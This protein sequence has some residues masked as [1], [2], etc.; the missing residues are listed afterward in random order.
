MVQVIL[1]RL[2]W[3]STKSKIFLTQKIK[4]TKWNIC[5]LPTYIPQEVPASRIQV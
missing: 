3:G 4:G 2:I 1:E 5:I